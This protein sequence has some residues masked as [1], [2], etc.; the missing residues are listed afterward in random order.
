MGR[1]QR[2]AAPAVAAHPRPEAFCGRVGASSNSD[3]T[4][5]SGDR[6]CG[7]NNSSSRSRLSGENSRVGAGGGLLERGAGGVGG[8]RRHDG[9]I[10]RKGQGGQGWWRRRIRSSGGGSLR[11]FGRRRRSPMCFV[12]F[13][14]VLCCAVLG[15]AGLCGAA[16]HRPWGRVARAWERCRPR[17]PYLVVCTTVCCAYVFACG[18][19]AR[20][21]TSRTTSFDFS[22]PYAANFCRA[23]LCTL[24]RCASLPPPLFRRE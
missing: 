17:Q 10:R 14:A 8:Y 16:L 1:P 7:V 6:S 3:R 23:F 22:C 15:G 20:L 2:V 4:G 24:H 18:S 13:L 5:G 12:L 21:R 9:E 19:P 11:R